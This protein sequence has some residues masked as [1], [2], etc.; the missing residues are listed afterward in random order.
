MMALPQFASFLVF[1]FHALAPADPLEVRVNV[2]AG[3]FARQDT[4][5]YVD[6][7]LSPALFRQPAVV[8]DCNQKLP[9][10]IEPLD[11]G[12]ARIWWILPSIGKGQTKDLLIRIGGD[13]PAGQPIFTWK[14]SSQAPTR[15]MDLLYDTR[16][17]LRYM[18]T[19]YQAETKEETR[20][21]FHHVYSPDGSRLLT[22]GVGGKFTHHRGIFFGYNKCGVDGQVYDTWHCDKGEH[23]LH[24]EVLRE[25]IG[26]V[27]GGHVVRIAWNDPKGEPFV[28][29]NRKLVVFAQPSGQLLIDFVSTLRP[30]R[31]PVMLNGDR[32]HAGAQFRAS[33]EVAENEKA[34][35][36]LRPEKWKNLPP[37][38]EVNTPEHK[39]LPWNAIQFK[40][41]DQPFT[42]AY[43]SAPANP[44]DAEFSER[45]YGRLGEFFPWEL[46]DDNRLTVHYR[47]WITATHDVTRERVETKYNDLAHPLKVELK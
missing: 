5:V 25:F 11:G 15:S 22:K 40:L 3:D 7:K 9:A 19:P 38:Q 31:G 4:P 24:Q 16:P 27:F 35:R 21:P 23:E 2:A 29:E 33:Q 1:I 10:Q 39:G 13:L 28:E 46:K 30:T 12:K 14:D 32:Q 41:G 17:V 44:K 20:K 43:L 36:Y 42:V 47:F 18:H 6:L 34:T 8:L 37:D 26:P 45:L